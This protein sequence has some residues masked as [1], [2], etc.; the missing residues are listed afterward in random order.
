MTDTTPG[1]LALTD[2][3]PHHDALTQA[4]HWI[5]L[6]AVCSAIAT[7]WIMEDL[8]KG[9]AKL[10]VVNLHASFGML[11][12]TLTLVRLLWRN[13]APGI[14]PLERP[15]WLYVAAKAMQVALYAL[16]VAIPLSGVLMMAAKGRSFEVFGLF[17]MA[18]VMQLDRSL[19]H[20]LEEIHE[21]MANLMIGLVGL[22]TL[23]ALM[24]QFVLK[25]DVLLRMSPFGRGQR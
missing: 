10:Q 9:P 11:I 19:A 23:A 15:W 22:H 20:S 21:V 24:H 16:L 18:P 12:M 17:T 8:P 6:L 1:A 14:A 4:L 25:D 3:R 7:G 2:S 13:A 5:S